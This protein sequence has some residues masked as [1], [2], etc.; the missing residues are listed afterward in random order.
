MTQEGQIKIQRGIVCLNGRLG[1]SGEAGLR[2]AEFSITQNTNS[3]K[4]AQTSVSK[5][6]LAHLTRRTRGSESCLLWRAV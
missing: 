3:S 1:V 4:V 5:M 6:S 2:N